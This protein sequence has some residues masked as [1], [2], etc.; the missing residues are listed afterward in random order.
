TA[1]ELECSDDPDAPA[2]I[3]HILQRPGGQVGCLTAIRSHGDRQRSL[4]VR[5][6][7]S[8]PPERLLE[9]SGF[10]VSS[11]PT[12][13]SSTAHGVAPPAAAS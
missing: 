9:E 5:M 7:L 12:T 13:G 11:C 10:P 3:R 6:P 2:R 1:I 4:R 8:A